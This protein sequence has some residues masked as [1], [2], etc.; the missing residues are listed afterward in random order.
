MSALQP[1]APRWGSNQLVTPGAASARVTISGLTKQIRVE[2]TGATNPAYIRCGGSTV[3]A[4][5]ADL[6]VSP[7]KAVVV[8][9]FQDD[10]YVAYIS[11]AG[12]TLEIMEC[13]G[14]GSV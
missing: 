5:T 11:A 2:N 3:T 4:T 13:E 12:T 9:K 7:G 8:T 10:A 6:R 14:W 1:I